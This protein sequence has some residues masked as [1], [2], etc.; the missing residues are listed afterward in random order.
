LANLRTHPFTQEEIRKAKA[1][2]LNSWIFNFDSKEAVLAEK[3]LYEFYGYPLDTLEHFRQGVEKTTLADVNRAVEKY[4]EGK[5]FAIVVVG[6]SSDFDQPL[7]TFGT[8]KNIDVTIP[9]TPPSASS[10]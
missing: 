8:V 9:T 7:S 10:K 6:K 2:I 4:I 3:M 5:Q 1:N